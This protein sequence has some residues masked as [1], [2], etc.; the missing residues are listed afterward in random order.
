MRTNLGLLALSLSLIV[1]A[2]VRS[3]RAVA[4]AAAPPISL[5][6]TAAAIHEHP[7]DSVWA[8]AATARE[9]D[10]FRLSNRPASVTFESTL[11]PITGPQHTTR[12]PVLRPALAVRAIVGGPPWS[13]VMDGIP[14]QPPNTVVTAGS[15]FDSIRIVSIS[16]DSVIVEG[17]DTTWHLALASPAQ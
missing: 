4:T 15:V 11:I 1:V 16:A 9:Y 2:S 3:L 14:G 6:D 7:P 12:A 10:A 17:F 13:A 5:L 8:A